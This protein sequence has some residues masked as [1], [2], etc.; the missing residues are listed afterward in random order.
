MMVHHFLASDSDGLAR[1]FGMLTSAHM[2]T[3]G[4]ARGEPPSARSVIGRI[5]FIKSIFACVVAR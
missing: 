1:A 5:S 4:S 3:S 2:K